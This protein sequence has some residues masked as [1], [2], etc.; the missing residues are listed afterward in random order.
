M[1]Q[2][3]LVNRIRFTTSIKNELNTALNQLSNETRIPKSKL[4][5]EAIEDLLK[6]YKKGQ[7]VGSNRCASFPS[8][9]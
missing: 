3:K 5:D 7:I 4:M 8:I 2:G 1:N 9:K 6:K